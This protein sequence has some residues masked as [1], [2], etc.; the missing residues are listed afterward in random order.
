MPRRISHAKLISIFLNIMI[1]FT[2]Q[3]YIVDQ[4]DLSFINANK[5][6]LGGK[7]RY[8]FHTSCTYMNVNCT[9]TCNSVYS[10][11]LNYTSVHVK[12][13]TTLWHLSETYQIGCSVFSLD[14]ILRSFRRCT[15]LIK[16]Q[17]KIGRASC[18]ERV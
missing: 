11:W 12:R 16:V 5:I 18:R 13:L 3:R 15:M 14:N 10:K 2:Y 8:T 17:S 1:D 9:C 4:M 6:W 7:Y